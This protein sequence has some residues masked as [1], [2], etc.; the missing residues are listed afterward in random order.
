M[1]SGGGGGEL[2]PFWSNPAVATG[3]SCA[4]TPSAP[5]AFVATP[6]PGL[7]SVPSAPMEESVA[8]LRRR[9]FSNSAANGDF[10]T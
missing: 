2:S 6:A 8:L 1:D 7:L 5:A 3:P 9:R 4:S 10:S